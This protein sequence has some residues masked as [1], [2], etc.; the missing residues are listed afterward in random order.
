MSS[1]LS[2]VE[3]FCLKIQP[4]FEKQDIEKIKNILNTYSLNYNIT[5]NF[6][7][8]KNENYQLP[9]A[10]YIY[11]AAK[12][13]QGRMSEKS[14]EQYKMCLQDML[15]YLSLPLEKITI[16]HLRLY[17]QYISK[18]KK[19]GKP[20]STETLNQRKSIIRSF[21]KWL[22][23][24][25]YIQK[26]PS[27]RIR[28]QKSN[29]K[30]R[31]QYTDIDIEQIRRACKTNRDI[32]IVDLLISSG[33]RVS[34]CV[35]LNIKDVDLNKREILVCGKGGKWRTVYIDAKTVVSIKNYINERKDNNE[36]LFVSLRFPY[37][38]LS[39]SGVR[40]RL[41]QLTQNSGVEDIIPHRFRYTMATTAINRGMPIESIQNILGHSQLETT[42]HYA[43]VSDEKVR[44]DHQKYI[45]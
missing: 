12:E 16:N 20:L 24:E 15:K 17:I 36:A 40:K 28:R 22:Y 33:I 21:F 31:Q 5:P 30:P 25:E 45:R 6:I 11:M 34:E 2:F 3:G 43:H 41:H 35:G 23:E 19:T 9:E 44:Q 32:A 42:L 26:D 13:Q 8:L 14:K 27:V 38:R 7:D 39:T 29:V 1:N 18:N 10:Y 4:F 37:N